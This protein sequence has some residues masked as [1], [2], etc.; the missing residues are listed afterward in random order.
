MFVAKHISLDTGKVVI[1][2][3]NQSRHKTGLVDSNRL[4]MARN[5]ST[6]YL[7]GVMC[8]AK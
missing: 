8:S 3:S 7:V 6:V 5:T 2:D 4:F 1:R